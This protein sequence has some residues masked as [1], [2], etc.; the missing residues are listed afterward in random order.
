[1]RTEETE[2][3]RGQLG[4]QVYASEFAR[5]EDTG[6][7]FASSCSGWSRTMAIFEPVDD[8]MN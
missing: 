3:L 7:G 8:G 6:R 4:V 5:Y 1:M 2:H